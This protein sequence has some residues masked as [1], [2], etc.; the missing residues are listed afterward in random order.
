MFATFA[1]RPEVAKRV[2]YVLYCLVHVQ[3]DV[4][5]PPP[6]LGSGLLAPPELYFKALRRFFTF[7]GTFGHVKHAEPYS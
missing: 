3:G 4:Y 2:G 6:T 1:S 7:L 5:P